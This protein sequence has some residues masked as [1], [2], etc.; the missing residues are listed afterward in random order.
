MAGIDPNDE[1]L[2]YV[3]PVGLVVAPV[4]LA[5]YGLTPAIQTK[6]DTDAVREFVSQKPEDGK[7]KGAGS[8]ALGDP[9]AFFAGTLGWRAAQVAGAPGGPP[10]PEDL[11]LKVE[12]CDTE[13]G[14]DWAIRDPDGGW[15]VLARIEPPGVKPE[16]RGALSG[17]EATPQQRFERLLREKQIPI[18]IQIADE[19]LR[20]IH[21]PRG[22]TSGWLTFPLRSLAEVGGRPMLGGLKLLLS[23]F[24]L[25]NDAPEKRLPGLLKASREAQAEVSTRLAAQVLGALHELL[26]GLHAADRERIEGL[27][28]DAPEH[29]YDGLLVVLL[30]LVFLL[31]AEDRDLIPSRT[32]AE[33]RAF[34]GQGYGVR[35]LYAQLLDDCA[36]HPDTMDERRGAWGRLLAV[37]SLLHHGD[38]NANWIRGRGGRL[39]DPAVYPFLQGQEKPGEAPAPAPV[40]D[41]C[42]LRILDALITVD[43]E[44]LSYRTLDVEQIGSV[45]ETVMGFTIETRAGPAVAIKAGKNDHTPV[46][47]DLAALV[48]AKGTERAKFLKEEAGRNAL[49]DKVGKALAGAK[50]P[51]EVKEALRLIVDERGSPGGQASPPGTPLLQPTDERRRTGSHYTPRSLTRPIVQ[52]ALAPAFERIGPDARPEDVLALKVCD[53]AMGSGAFLVEACRALG[54]RLVHAWAR[55]PETRP[56][57]P[58]DEDEPLHARRLVAQRCLYGVDKNPRAVELAKLSLWLA[59]LARDHEFTFL[60][61][62]LKCG[63]SL[64]GLDAKQIAAVH[65]DLSKPGLPLFRKFVAD[66]VA[67]ATKARAEIQSA[68]DDTTRA[69]LEAKHHAVEGVISD[70]RVLGDAVI[71]AFFAED[72]LKAREKR[73]AT[74]ESWVAGSPIKWDELRAAAVSLRTGKHPLLPFHWELEFPEVFSGK[75]GGFDAIVGN[76]P[77]A[78]KNTTI[79][80]QRAHYLPW[81]Q[82]LHAGA[83]GNS[84]LVA[85]F[86]RRAFR[87]LGEGGVFGFVATNTIGQGDTRD[88]G[89]AAIL[90]EGG[91]IACATRRLKWP[92]EAAVVVSIVHVKKGTVGYPVLDGRHVRRISAYLVDGELDHSPALLASNNRK[93]FKG[94]ELHGPGFL[95]DDEGAAK[96]E[97]ESICTMNAIIASD[98]RN[99]ERIF[100][101]VGSHLGLRISN[102]APK[103]PS[104]VRIS[105]QNILTFD[106]FASPLEV[107]P[108]CLAYAF[109][110]PWVS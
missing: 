20:L 50:T 5:R 69:V 83:H 66:R 22:E 102:L 26:R 76:P 31:Y 101:F 19:E 46:F 100:P 16:E 92:G 9:W 106:R 8:R 59:T 49:S 11:F 62:A 87:L 40:S 53:P 14:P 80:G 18:G 52:H 6:G 93:V 74:I 70:V 21:A 90:G 78:G 54:D 15:Q 43:G 51:A 98:P 86:F 17:W 2:G 42:I 30:R 105:T 82:T 88:T 99:A 60:D 28:H 13:I 73:R 67:E 65:W 55:W 85:H 75:N 68:P 47:V 107:K 34:Y 41:G 12:E 38:G 27:A 61:H 64:V 23:S 56:K 79:A 71:S 84:D 81:L 35:S 108:G 45:Y 77:F 72:K 94:S 10:L 89:L 37:F 3:Q 33:A 97:C 109:E 103:K 63:D 48:A 39:F 29:L 91:A 32:D 7:A 1:W 4:V 57:I 104:N 44:K 96:G 58:E 36:R 110:R 95:F 25:H 24:R